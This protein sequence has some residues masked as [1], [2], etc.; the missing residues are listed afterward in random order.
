MVVD[1]IEIR[2]YFG[3]ELANKL[4]FELNCLSIAS[5]YKR[6]LQNKL[7]SKN[8]GKAIIYLSDNQGNTGKQNAVE[9]LLNIATIQMN[10]DFANYF[11]QNAYKKRL[12]ILDELHKGAIEIAKHFKWDIK[13]L[14]EAYNKCVD[15]KLENNWISE[16]LKTKSS[17][18]HKYKA[19]VYFEY[20]NTEIRV[21]LIIYDKSEKQQQKTLVFTLNGLNRNI[22]YPDDIMPIINGKTKWLKDEFILSDK[23]NREIGRTKVKETNIK[24]INEKTNSL[25][26][27]KAEKY[28][29]P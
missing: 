29:K 21:Y 22:M 20:D 4:K 25:V 19:A 7:I 8:H 11:K 27:E 18:N 13:P 12:L 23:N 6:N 1:N 28:L 10:F 26:A 24:Y 2:P 5:L 17:A 16:K 15:A 3:T 9:D 14:N